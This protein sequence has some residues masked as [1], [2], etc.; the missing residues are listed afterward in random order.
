MQRRDVENMEF[1]IKIADGSEDPVN[2]VFESVDLLEIKSVLRE[3][4]WKEPAFSNR[5]VLDGREPDLE[6]Q[7]AILDELARFHIRL[8]VYRGR[9]VG[10]VHLDVVP[11]E[12]LGDVLRLLAGRPHK[13]NHVAGADFICGLFLRR[14]YAVEVKKEPYV[15]KILKGEAK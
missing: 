7:Y 14:G 4:G 13:S 3:E 15:V 6:L 12:R 2:V 11:M 9:I 8:F 10:N 5:A 1:K